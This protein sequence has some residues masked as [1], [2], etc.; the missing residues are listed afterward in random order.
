[1]LYY[2]FSI[3]C[4]LFYRKSVQAKHSAWNKFVSSVRSRLTVAQVVESVRADAELTFDFLVLLL[5]ATWVTAIFF[6]F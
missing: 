5:I 1:M 6:T 4:I 2:L 3:I